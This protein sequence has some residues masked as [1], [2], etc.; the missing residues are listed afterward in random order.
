MCCTCVYRL[1]RAAP[2]VAKAVASIGVMVLFTAVF[3]VR[4]GTTGVPVKP[5]TDRHTWTVGHVRITPGPGVAGAR[6]GH[7]V[8]W[9]PS[10]VSLASGS[11]AGG[12]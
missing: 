3:T 11:S 8:V 2:L 6:G 12:R 5:I 7:Y 1:L 9:P 4:V 10:T